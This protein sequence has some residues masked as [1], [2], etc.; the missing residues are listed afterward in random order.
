MGKILV[1]GIK[2]SKYN[3]VKFEYKGEFNLEDYKMIALA[4]SDLEDRFNA[5]MRKAFEFLYS[6]DKKVFPI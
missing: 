4:L 6:K 5:P 1:V 3:K 2:D